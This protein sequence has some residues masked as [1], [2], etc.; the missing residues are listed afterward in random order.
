MLTL[1]VQLD[2]M[3]QLLYSDLPRTLPRIRTS[4]FSSGY[5]RS[6]IRY[7]CDFDFGVAVCN[8]R[9]ICRL[10]SET[11]DELARIIFSL[12]IEYYSV[13]I[14][15]FNLLLIILMGIKSFLKCFLKY[16]C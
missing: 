8:I 3:H 13:I 4:A 9:L 14:F 6:I 2:L 7:Q 12:C 5:F 10:S 15:T 16:I 1:S 11:F